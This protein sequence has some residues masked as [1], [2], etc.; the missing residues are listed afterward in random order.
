MS[1]ILT[2]VPRTREKITPR[3]RWRGGRS[4]RLLVG[5]VLL[6]LAI[7]VL[8]IIEVGPLLWLLLSSF[9]ADKEFTLEPLWALPAGLDWQNYINAVT[10]GN[11]GTYF[12]NSLLTVFPA[13]ALI[14]L[15]GLAAGFALEV[16]VWRGRNTVLLI[17]LAGILVPVQIVLLP[18]FTIYFQA[19]LIDTRWAL[20]IT[21][22]GFGL[23]LTVFLMATYFKAI[24]RE[25]IEAAV[26]D[27][28]NIYQIF[29]RVGVPMVMNGLVTVALVQFFFL[30]NDLLFSLTFISSDSLRTIQTG[31]LNFTG[32]Y[33]QIQWGPT[34][35]AICLAVFPTL[36]L[37]L[38][39]NQRVIKGLTAG[40]LK[41]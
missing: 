38:I 19:Q 7:A 14:L 22:T 25:M 5:R 4:A 1:Y 16:M 26:L 21:Y 3:T 41:G 39:L 24:P 9:K 33:G 34:F 29:L 28:A 10:T 36:L 15:F 11:I 31:L 17:F 13:L 35:A 12:L 32:E 2:N 18:L 37:Y 23:P 8:L 30:W 20:I 40:S 27:G 6:W